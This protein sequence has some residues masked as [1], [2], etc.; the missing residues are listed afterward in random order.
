[1][2]A[3][4]ANLTLGHPKDNSSDVKKYLIFSFV[5]PGRIFL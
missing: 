2:P 5:N 3:T 1:M 4:T